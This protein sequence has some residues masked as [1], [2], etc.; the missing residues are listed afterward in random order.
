MATR[1]EF[2]RTSYVKRQP[3]Q[4]LVLF[5]RSKCWKALRAFQ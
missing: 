2:E 1:L 4:E 3:V 5:T